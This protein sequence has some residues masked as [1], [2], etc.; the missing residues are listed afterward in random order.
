[1]Q[2]GGRRALVTGGGVRVGRGLA[3]AL[4]QRGVHVAVHYHGSEPGARRS[5]ERD[6]ERENRFERPSK[7]M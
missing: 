2:L 1:M 7:K 6:L 5:L 4:V 3:A